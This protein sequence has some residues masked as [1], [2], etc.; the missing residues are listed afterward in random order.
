MKEWKMK[1]QFRV[2][3]GTGVMEM[4]VEIDVNYS[5]NPLSNGG[6]VRDCPMEKTLTWK[7][8]LYRYYIERYSRFPRI[9][10]S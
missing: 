8:G 5:L 3:V 9:E 4:E 1:L 10:G 6:Y 7:R 2:R